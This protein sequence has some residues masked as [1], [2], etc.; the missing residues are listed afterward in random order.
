MTAAYKSAIELSKA[1]KER[2]PQSFIVFG[3]IHPTAVPDEVLAHEHI[4]VVIRGEAEKTL[5]DFY[6]YIKAGQTYTHLNGLSYRENGKIIHNRPGPVVSDLNDLPAFPYHLFDDKK[7]NLS[8]I[9]SSRGCPYECIF[10]SNRIITG[11]KYRYRSAESTMEELELLFREYGIRHVFFVDDNFIVNHKRAF[12]IIELIRKSGIC[13]K[14][15]FS[16]QGRADN[17]DY[18]LFKKL[19]ETGFTSVDFGIETASERIMKIINK[20]ETV[21][22]CVKAVKAAKEIGLHV[23]SSFIY[24]L[25]TET[26]QDR[27]DAIRLSKQLDIDIVKFNNATPFP[28]TVLFEIA[29]KEGKLNIHGLYENFN[30]VSTIIENPFKKIPFS[31]IPAGNTEQEIR[32]DIILSYMA[33]WFN[34]KRMTKLLTKPSEGQGWFN[35]GESIIEKIRKVPPLFL[36]GGALMIKC[37][38]ALLSVPLAKKR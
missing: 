18:R 22:E 1:L 16:F 37:L 15:T 32:R 4:D 19:Y 2:Y 17:F 29:K 3:G 23:T 35:A 31:Y 11:K 8:F 27:M 24:A 28:G 14:M 7:Y 34:W 30:S 25:P 38:E 5:N 10:C 12:K 20:G 36:L 33:L 13:G 21:A 6:R 9:F 26:H